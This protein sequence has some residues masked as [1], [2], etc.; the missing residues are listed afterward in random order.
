MK[1]KKEIIEHY[2]KTGAEQNRLKK[3]NEGRVEEERTKNILKRFL[4]RAPAV[5]HDIGGGA[6]AYSFFLAEQGYQVHLSDLVDLHIEQAKKENLKSKHKLE[7]LK[8]ED[9]RSLSYA[10]ESSDVVLLL[11]P[12]YHL[13][14]KEDRIKSLKE[15]YRVLKPGGILFAAAISRYASMIDGLRKEYCFEKYYLEMLDE[16]FKT[17]KN[18]SKGKRDHFTT[19]YFHKPDELKEEL[20]ESGF[21]LLHILAIEGVAWTLPNLDKYLADNTNKKNLLELIQKTESE[22]SLLGYSPHLMVVAV[23]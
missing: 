14:E 5:I 10:S 23:K 12:L 3:K 11:G 19:A 9:A 1:D 7:S 8:I 2:S 6:G 17:G 20:E 22:P 16:T 18:I 4:P 15:A 21:K 13:T